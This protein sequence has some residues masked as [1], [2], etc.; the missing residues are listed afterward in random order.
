MSQPMTGET[1][2]PKKTA[3]KT[4]GPRPKRGPARPYRKLEQEV[5]DSR[6]TKL[7]KRLDRAKGQMEEAETFLKKYE[8]EKGFRGPDAEAEAKSE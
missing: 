1:P 7:T 4:E 2:K 3:K 8:R 6:I 5:L